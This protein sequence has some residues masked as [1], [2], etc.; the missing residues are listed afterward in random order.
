MVW[1][2][3]GLGEFC[4]KIA[5]NIQILTKVCKNANFDENS[6]KY[7]FLTKDCRKYANLVKRSGKIREFFRKRVRKYLLYTFHFS[8]PLF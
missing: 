4:R 1:G 7:D 5:E 3:F 2:K 8:H 6:Q